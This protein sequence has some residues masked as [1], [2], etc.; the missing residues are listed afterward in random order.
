[1]IVYRP[2]QSV[3]GICFHVDWEEL[4]P[5]LLL[6]VGPGLNWEDASIHLLVKE[7]LRPLRSPSTLEEDEGPENFLLVAAELLQSQMQIQHVGV[8]ESL[9]GTPFIKEVWKRGEFWP[10][11]LFRQSGQN[12]ERGSN[13]RGRCR[14]QRR[15]DS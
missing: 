4:T 5:E 1:L 3:D 2:L 7:V 11:S 9:T 12:R 8:K 6:E 15:S 13:W 14:Y 10:C